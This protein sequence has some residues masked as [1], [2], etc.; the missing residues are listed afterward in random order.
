MTKLKETENLWIL[1]LFLGITG[2][3][4]ALVLAVF[5]DLVR[6]PIAA[7]ELRSTNQAL[8]QILPPFDNQPSQ[9]VAT[10]KGAN[11]AEYTFMGAFKEGQL[12]ALAATGAIA[13]YAG[14]VQAMVGLNPDGTIRAVLITRQNET[15]GLGANVCERKFQKTIFNLFEPVPE[16]VAP[17]S[18]LDQFNGKSA[19]PAANWKV[20][21]DG[22]SINYVT[23]ATVTCRAVTELVSE[24]DRCYLANKAEIIGALNS[25]EGK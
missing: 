19:D 11:G 1:G 24:L 9:T 17:N 4:S 12:V 13:G 3:I 5:S 14:P 2:L 18:F 16:G 21:K 20:R 7:A 8:Q 22:G 25:Q 10:I 23:G 15:P 6:E